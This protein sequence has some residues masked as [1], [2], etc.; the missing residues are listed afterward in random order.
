M[1]TLFVLRERQKNK[2]KFSSEATR[3]RFMFDYFLLPYVTL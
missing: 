3:G 2:K 1:A